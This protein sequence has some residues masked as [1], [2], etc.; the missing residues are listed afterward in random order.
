MGT[1]AVMTGEFQQ[2]LTAHVSDKIARAQVV[3]EP[4]G[5]TFIESLLT[6]DAYAELRAFK[7]KVRSA[8]LLAPRRQDSKMFVNRR[9]S[10]YDSGEPVAR[11]LFDL[12]S[13]S[14]VKRAF[15]ELFYDGLSNEALSGIEVHRE[16]EIVCSKP[17]LFQ[18]IHVDIPPKMM[19][20]VL[21]LPDD[22]PSDDEAA[23]NA[24]LLYDR[25]LRPAGQARFLPN[26]ACAFAPHF[27]SYHGFSTTIERDA[28]VM[29]YVD[30]A[31]LRRWQFRQRLSHLP[32]VEWDSPAAIRR[33]TARRLSRFQL[34]EYGGDPRVL[35]LERER[36]LVNAPMGRVRRP[37]S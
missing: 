20:L 12:F 28:L 22:R 2:R 27:Y 8:G 32:F 15:L 11:S 25:A 30:R 35:D 36:C 18:D 33:A 16:F 9:F 14:V 5:H 34:R 17:N 26:A 21:Y 1:G 19:S 24:T 23:Q 31:E 29:F 7:Q 37:T 3:L 13:S 6:E 10:L 4:F